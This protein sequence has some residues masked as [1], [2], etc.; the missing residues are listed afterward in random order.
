MVRRCGVCGGD[1]KQRRR[2][3]EAHIVVN[4]YRCTAVDEGC[5]SGGRVVRDRA[6]GDEIRRVGPIFESDDE[7]RRP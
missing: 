3:I 7:R 1:V 2:D 5:R 6:S 4:H